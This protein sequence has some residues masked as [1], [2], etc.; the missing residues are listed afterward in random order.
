MSDHQYFCIH[1]DLFDR[2]QSTHQDR[3]ILWRFILNEPN[4]DEYN[5][6]ATEIHNDNIQNKKRTDNKY[7]TKHTLHRRRQKKVDYRKN[8]FD[9]FRV[10]IVDPPPKLNSDESDVHEMKLFIR[11]Y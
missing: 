11:W 7:S 4:E 10:I 1:D 8:S 9:A 3:N 5:S 2:I 6:E